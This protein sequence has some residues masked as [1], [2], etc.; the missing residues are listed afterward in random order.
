MTR[1]LLFL[2]LLCY[3]C[4]C[5]GNSADISITVVEEDKEPVPYYGGRCTGSKPCTACKN[6]KYCKHCSKQGGTCG[7]CQ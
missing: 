4:A 6:C 3:L 7:V 1:N 5:N 2:L